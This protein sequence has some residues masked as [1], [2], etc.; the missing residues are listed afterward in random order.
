M[1]IRKVRSLVAGVTFYPILS[2][3]GEEYVVILDT[4][5]GTK[6]TWICTCESWLNRGRVNNEPCKHCVRVQENILREKEKLA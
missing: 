1:R 4:R 6:H 3:S 2:D 5:K